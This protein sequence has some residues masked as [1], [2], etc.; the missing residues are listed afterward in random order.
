MGVEKMVAGSVNKLGRLYTLFLRMI[1]VESGEIIAS[2]SIDCECEI[3]EVAVKSTKEAI[4]LLLFDDYQGGK[5]EGASPDLDRQE[6]ILASEKSRRAKAEKKFGIGICRNGIISEFNYNPCETYFGDVGGEFSKISGMELI[7]LYKISNYFDLKMSFFSQTFEYKI[8]GFS[9]SWGNVYV[10]IPYKYIGIR[11][12][13]MA[14]I[15]SYQT[16]SLYTELGISA[17]WLMRDY[18]T[19]NLNYGFQEV[20]LAE[21]GP[22]GSISVGTGL[23]Y[24]SAIG[25]FQ[26]GIRYHFDTDSH[27]ETISV[28]N[29]PSWKI[30]KDVFREILLIETSYI[31]EF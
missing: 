26:I 4:Q 3:E 23:N 1:D 13:I 31:Y 10:L 29:Y 30:E 8:D 2:S 24:R 11:P 21:V 22:Y 5:E 17:F 15:Y 16:F 18:V 28:P 14:N 7:G 19:Y 6:A 12:A 9:P 27:E 25:R 20:S